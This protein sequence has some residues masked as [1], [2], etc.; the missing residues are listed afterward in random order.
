M[1]T[2]WIYN[3]FVQ[4]RKQYY[5]LKTRDSIDRYDNLEKH[6]K[7]YKTFMRFCDEIDEYNAQ[8]WNVWYD[9]MED[10]QGAFE[11]ML[12]TSQEKNLKYYLY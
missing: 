3:A 5:K 2:Q 4:L 1:Y 8:R 11:M 9:R 6:K 12:N 7:K 10:P